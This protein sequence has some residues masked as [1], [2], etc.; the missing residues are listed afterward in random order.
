M[1]PAASSQDVRIEL[2]ENFSPF[3]QTPNLMQLWQ[4]W[5]SKN[6]FCCRGRCMR[7]PKSDRHYYYFTW[8]VILGVNSFFFIEVAPYLWR[9]LSPSVPAVSAYLFLSSLVFLLLT[10][11]TEPGIIPRKAVFELTGPV[12]P[13]Y[14]SDILEIDKEHGVFYTCCKTCKIFRPPRSH[15]CKYCDNCVEL[16][17]HHCHW[18]NNCIGKRNYCFFLSFVCSLLL[19]GI[20]NLFG[21]FAYFFLDVD[22]DY[23][24]KAVVKD[25]TTALTLVIIF[26]VCALFITLLLAT[27]CLCHLYLCFT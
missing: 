2:H 21:F 13:V 26:C 17:D 20:C 1:E 8:I 18:L 9:E 27:L 22:E 4:A 14:T 15:H 25:N 19:L 5:P 16:F 24:D 11:Y 10:T 3:T 23:K 6:Q 7:G 12:P